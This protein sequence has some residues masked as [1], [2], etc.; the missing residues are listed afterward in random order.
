MNADNACELRVLSGLHRGASLPVDDQPQLIGGADD[1]DVVLVDPG[2]APRHA[3]LRL[4]SGGWSLLSVDGTVRGASHDAPEDQHALALGQ[5][6]RVGHVWL[7]VVPHGA[8]WQDPPPD[9]PA[10]SAPV[11]SEAE[12]EAWKPAADDSAG[13]DGA[14]DPAPPDYGDDGLAADDTAAAPADGVA[15]ADSRLDQTPQGAT[16]RAAPKPRRGRM[17]LPVGLGVA[18][19]AVTTYAYSSRTTAPAPALRSLESLAVD[20]PGAD[21]PGATMLLP[22]SLT[23]DSLPPGSP[24]PLTVKPAAAPV[25]SPEALRQ[26]FR[27]RLAEVDLLRRVDLQLD[28]RAWTV[29][30]TL[31]DDEAARLR[32]ILEAFVGVHHIAFPVNVHVGGPDSMLPFRVTQVI[33]GSNASIVTEDGR[34][35][36]P[37]DDYLGVKLVAIDGERLR[38]AGARPIEVKW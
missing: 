34:R 21:K 31:D 30:A 17:T 13:F 25:M 16:P 1:A 29:R 35:L 33:S 2:M 19:L 37:G 24:G 9:P 27:Q 3:M 5:P 4:A 26:A 36:Y 23:L 15:Q 7:T 22:G 38:F 14:A 8:A 18:L 28:E 10:G 20:T 6:A 12:A 11:A 32:R